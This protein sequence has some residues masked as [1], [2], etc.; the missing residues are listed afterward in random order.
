MHHRSIVSLVAVAALATPIAASAA[1]SVTLKF[2]TAW[3][4][5]RGPGAV[6][7]SP[8]RQVGG[9]GDQRAHQIQVQ[10]PRG[11]Q[12]A[13][14]VPADVARRVRHEPQRRALLR[15]HHRRADGLLR[16]SRRHRGLAQE[17]LL[18][19]RRR[20]NAAVQPEDGRASRRR[21]EG[22][23]LPHHAEAAPGEGSAAAQ[24]AQDPGQRVLHADR[25][26]ARRLHGQPQR[27][28]YLFRPAEGR[29][30]GRRLAGDGRDQ[31]QV[32]RGRQVHDAAALRRFAL[33]T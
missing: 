19:A 22:Q 25:Q 16:A 23:H 31:L 29:G 6:H 30:R 2:L 18:E 21:V 5:A 8:L 3:D 9:K 13:P 27:A 10:R 32:V 14:A 11:G 26:A 24:G 1:D 7:R 4:N 28:R 20:G 12:V 17:G 15:R 33:H